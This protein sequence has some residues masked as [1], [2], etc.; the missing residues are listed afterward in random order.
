MD[1]DMISGIAS[2]PEHDKIA[3][4]HGH[5][6]WSRSEGVFL[7]GEVHGVFEEQE[8]SFL[9]EGKVSKIGTSLTP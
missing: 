2:Y 4:I 8:G 5:I 1:L 3:F 6:M 9:V 7:V